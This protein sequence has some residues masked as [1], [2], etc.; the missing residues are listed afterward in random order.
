ME[1]VLLGEVKTVIGG[2]YSL[3]NAAN[4]FDDMID[5]RITGKVVV[6]P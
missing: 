4:A 6:E 5:G 2:T 3:E 1:R